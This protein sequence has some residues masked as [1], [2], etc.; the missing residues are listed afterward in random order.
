MKLIVIVVCLLSERY[1]IHSLSLRRFDWF[2]AYTG[3][4]REKI[5][6][7]GLKNSW[8]IFAA[9]LAPLLLLLFILLLAL[10]HV[11]FGIF[12]LVIN[13]FILFYCL[14][15]INPFYPVR[16]NTQKKQIK[17]ETENYLVATNASLFGVIFWYIV[18]GP[19]GALFYRLV[20]LSQSESTVKH[21]AIKAAEILDWIPAR[22][23]VISYLV[24]GDFQAGIGTFIKNLLT[25]TA[26][27]HK[28]IQ[29]CGMKALGKVEDEAEMLPN[30]ETLV[31]HAALFMM[32]FVAIF[33]IVSWL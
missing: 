2:S 15:P 21:V 1:F 11:L 10:G 25:P 13:I 8:G 31:E 5:K 26:N 29:E 12:G 22:F 20:Q 27:N 6:N 30:A 32:V 28:L 3:V 23:T 9:I 7:I 33:T 14:G 19:I 24:V 18:L 16:E 4:I 17:K